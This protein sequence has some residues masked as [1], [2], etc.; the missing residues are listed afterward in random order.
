MCYNGKIEYI[1]TD[2]Y[3]VV[4]IDKDGQF[5]VAKE[6]ADKVTIYIVARGENAESVDSSTSIQI[7]EWK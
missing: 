7:E 6:Q 3:N 1:E 2:D 4:E 5:V